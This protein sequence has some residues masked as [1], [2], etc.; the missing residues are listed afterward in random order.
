MFRYVKVMMIATLLIFTGCGSDSVKEAIEK[1][2]DGEVEV[3][4]KNKGGVIFKSEKTIV[5]NSYE[6]EECSY[7]Y[8]TG[9]EE[10]VGYEEVEYNLFIPTEINKEPY[11]CGFIQEPIQSSKVK[12]V[13]KTSKKTYESTYDVKNNG[14]I[15]KA[16][17][18]KGLDK[19][20]D[21][22]QVLYYYDE[23]GELLKKEEY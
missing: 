22:D 18:P 19:S 7:K 14:Y 5:C 10:G 9:G 16:P 15:G 1:T 17:Y 3:L 2:R 20:K 21:L 8:S 6:E 13:L 12:Y 4:N 23:S 11:L